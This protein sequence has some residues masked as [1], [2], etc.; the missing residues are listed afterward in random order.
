[1]TASYGGDTNDIG[2]SGT[3]TVAV[4]KAATKTAVAANPSSPI[5]GQ[6]TTLS[7]TVTVKSPGAGVPTGSVTFEDASGTLCSAS[8]NASTP[9][10]ASCAA[11]IG[12]P[13]S[14]TVTGIYE[15]DANFGG[16]DGSTAVTVGKG[17]STTALSSSANPAVTGQAVSFTAT[18]AAQAPSTGTPSGTVAFNFSGSG[19]TPN[20]KGGDTQTLSS[21]VATC[22]ISGGLQASQG[23]ETVHAI[24]SG[25]SGFSSSTATPLVETVNQSPSTVTISAG[26]NPVVTSAGVTFTA[27]LGAGSPGSGTPSSGTVTWTVT[28]AGGSAVACKKAGPVNVSSTGT[29]TCKV[30]TNEL[31]TAGEPYSVTAAFSGNGDYASSTGTYYEAVTTTASQV[32]LK[33]AAPASS[34]SPGSFT[35]VVTGVP[36][37]SVP[38][39]SDVPTGTV[40]FTI[41]DASGNAVSCDG[42]NNTVTLGG[43]GRATCSVSSSL[44]SSGSPYSVTAT[45]NGDDTFSPSTSPT[46]SVVVPG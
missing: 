45:Y 21:G 2:S 36:N 28:S 18:V 46:K 29:S 19:A 6:S 38:A 25:S 44:V 32:K 5:A 31:S 40:T 41:T 26:S 13:G 39:S 35:A 42:G 11:S 14:S 27:T 22:K 20:C 8:L 43:S 10:V 33:V 30:P 37:T 1:V 7:A 15:G 17:A 12:S 9:D 3:T 16:S 24:Y 34:G 23:Q 4:G